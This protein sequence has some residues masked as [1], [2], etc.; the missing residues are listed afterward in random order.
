MSMIKVPDLVLETLRDPKEVIL[1]KNIKCNDNGEVR[2]NMVRDGVTR[3]IRFLLQNFFQPVSGGHTQANMVRGFMEDTKS[4]ILNYFSAGSLEE[5]NAIW[6]AAKS[7]EDG[8]EPSE[9]VG[10]K[11]TSGPSGE[12]AA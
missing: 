3:R 10:Q 12:V 7:G 4:R 2:L 8:I 6:E 11:E 1:L 9:N 5:F